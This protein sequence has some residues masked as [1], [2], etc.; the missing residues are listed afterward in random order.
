VGCHVFEF[1][2]RLKYVRAGEGGVASEPVE[3]VLWNEKKRQNEVCATGL[4]MSRIV[5][6]DFYGEARQRA[7]QRLRSE[8]AVT[9][10]R[11]GPGLPE[12]LAAFERQ[13]RGRRRAS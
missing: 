6:A 13:M 9:L 7:R 4:G 3:D 12:H 8:Y 2:G 5:W 1:D 10:R 11:F